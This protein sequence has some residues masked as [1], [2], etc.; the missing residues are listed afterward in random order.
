LHFVATQPSLN[1]TAQ[2]VRMAALC[3]A[4]FSPPALAGP[5]YLTDDPEPVDYQH[6]EFYDFSQGIRAKGAT[7]GVAPSCDCN[8]GILP[9]VQLHLQPGAAFHRDKGGPSTYGAGD[10]ELGVKY[11]F[12]EQ[13]RNDW[14]P[15][16][17]F[18][19]LLETP[20][21]D[22]ARGLGAG[23]ARAFLP[24]WGQKD[25]GD[26]T[27]FG[28]G[29]FWINRGPSARSYA[30]VGWV[31]QRKLSDRLAVGFELFHQTPSQIG[32]MQA[33]GFNVGATYD[34]TE[35]YHLLVSAGKG[36][37]HARETNAF[38]WYLGLQVTDGTDQ[39][40]KKEKAAASPDQTSEVSWSGF[41]IAAGAGGRRQSA[42]ESDCISYGQI[43]GAA[44]G[45]GGGVFA[46]AAGVDRRLGAAALGVE[47]D[48]EAGA[49]V[50]QRQGLTGATL[51]SDLRSS[52]RL[53]GG[54]AEGRGLVYLTG[55]AAVANVF[56]NTL[57]ESFSSGRL[58]WTVGAGLEY[59]FTPE[60]SGRLEYRH[61]DFGRAIFRSDNF[62]G[63][64]YR[65]RLTDDSA[66]LAII[67]RFDFKEGEK[68]EAKD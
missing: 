43:P 35:H 66:R 52:L 36:L 60:W 13:D 63:N 50:A 17:A 15:S 2:C 20:S 10:T 7:D 51:K 21:G 54:V 22:A 24:I 45:K 6:W 19:P 38:S 23:R 1:F 68:G 16:V 40:P 8:Y 47:S 32:G 62:D 30:F 26:W 48:I 4:L 55:G 53:R 31:L 49:A 25:I 57:G 33:T 18:Y 27:T 64:Y 3:L 41:H 56:A 5:P 59:A 28:G 39:A 34:L 29:G 12:V 44:Y 58:G 14:A 42:W 67:Y 61:G 9:N 65:L 46:A 11:R 37:Q